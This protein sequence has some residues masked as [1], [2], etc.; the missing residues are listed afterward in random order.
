MGFAP[1]NTWLLI[2][3]DT[4]FYAIINKIVWPKFCNVL[5]VALLT[6]IIFF[7]Q[8]ML[9]YP[10]DQ[11]SPEYPV[12]PVLR[13]LMVSQAPKESLGSMDGQDYL[14]W[15]DRREKEDLKD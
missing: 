13:V 11:V 12:S 1:V 10:D 2:A 15:M 6:I 8:A 9:V 7:T 14:D 3:Y 4:V 5:S